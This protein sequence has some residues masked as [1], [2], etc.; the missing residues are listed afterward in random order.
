VGVRCGK[1]GKERPARAQ[2]ADAI[3]IRVAKAREDSIEC[4]LSFTISNS[5][6]KGAVAPRSPTDR[7][8]L[9]F[10]LSLLVVSTTR[11]GTGTYAY[12]VHLINITKRLGTSELA[13]LHETS[14][15][16]ALLQRYFDL[17]N[18]DLMST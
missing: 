17:P 12:A 8:V 18:V 15:V 9:R 4:L 7:T 10:T 6:S 3:L 5:P 14:T 1:Q 13:S 11:L 16:L 2:L